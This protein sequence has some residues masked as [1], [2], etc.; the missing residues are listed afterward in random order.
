V[1]VERAITGILWLVI[2]VN[3]LKPTYRTMKVAPDLRSYEPV[4]AATWLLAVNRLTFT[5]VTQY[6]PESDDALAICYIF[7][8]FGAALMIFCGSWSRRLGR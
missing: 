2:V 6:L 8:G 5:G 1:I 7:A 3:F 4:M